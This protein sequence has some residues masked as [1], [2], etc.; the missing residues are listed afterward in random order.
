MDPEWSQISGESKVNMTLNW[1]MWG[2][3]VR[4]KEE[5]DKESR[6]VKGRFT[7]KKTDIANWL[8]NTKKGVRIRAVQPLGWRCLG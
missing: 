7:K 4:E 2:E 8:Y 1:A 5:P 3:G 6:E